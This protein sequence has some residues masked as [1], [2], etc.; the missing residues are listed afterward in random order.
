M[1]I[2]L[3]PEYKQ[4]IQSRIASGRYENADDVIALAFKLLEEWEKGYQEWE[5]KTRKKIAVGL[6]QIE[7][8]EV[9]DRKVVIARLE[10]KLRQALGSQE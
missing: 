8:G 7:G 9:S 1:N 5:E 2:E 4:F 10:E 3:K 6:A